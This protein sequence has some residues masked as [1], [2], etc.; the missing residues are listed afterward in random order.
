MRRSALVPVLLVLLLTAPLA[1]EPAPGEW[2]CPYA[3]Y[4]LSRNLLKIVSQHAKEASIPI[5]IHAAES[6]AEM[7]FFFDSEGPIAN[8][9]ESAQI[10]S[11]VLL[12]RL[13]VHALD[14][15]EWTLVQ[16]QLIVETIQ[17]TN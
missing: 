8:E 4:L 11:Q 7:E 3:P 6:F 10:V 15:I 5:Q 1:S 17:S 2:R 13:W 12:A 14:M 16:P 9:A